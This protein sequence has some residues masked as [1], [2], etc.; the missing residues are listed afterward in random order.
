[1]H[2]SDESQSNRLVLPAAPDIVGAARCERG[3]DWLVLGN[4]NQ[5]PSEGRHSLEAAVGPADLETAPELGQEAVDG[6]DAEPRGPEH[7]EA[8][9]TSGE[10]PSAR[11]LLPLALILPTSAS[12]PM[13]RTAS[14]LSP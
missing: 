2:E 6:S 5:G 11:S 12:K 9:T 13:A 4:R 7:V 1:M 3:I 10:I 14:S 8:R